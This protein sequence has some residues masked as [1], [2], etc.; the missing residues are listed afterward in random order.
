MPG[1]E[2]HVHT[3]T[4]PPSPAPGRHPGRFRPAAWL[5]LLLALPG[6]ALGAALE[7]EAGPLVLG[8]APSAVVTL[9]LDDARPDG[10]RLEADRPADA[11]MPEAPLRLAASAGAFGPAER[12]GPGAYR[13]TYTLPTTRFPQIVLVA[14]WPGGTPDPRVELLRLPLHGTTRLTVKAPAGRKVSVEVGGKSFGPVR[15]GRSGQAVVPIVVPPGVREARVTVVGG[16]RPVVRK[17]ALDIP[18]SRR[19][20]AVAVPAEVVADGR[21]PVRVEVLREGDPGE[22]EVAA[23][24]IRVVASEGEVSLARAGPGAFTFRYVPAPGPDREVRFD[25]TVDGEEGARSEARLAVRAA[26]TST[27]IAAASA[28]ST[29]PAGPP[30]GSAP[31]EPSPARDLVEGSDEPGQDSTPTSGVHLGFRLGWVDSLGEVAGSR[32]G[33]GAWV[34]LRFG[35]AAFGAELSLS[36]GTTGA[37]TGADG[38]LASGWAAQLYPLTVRL[39]YEPWS[40]GRMTLA[41]GLGWSVVLARFAGRAGARQDAIGT[42]VLVFAAARYRVGPGHVFG[43]ASLGAAP[44]STPGLRVETAGL[45]LDAGYR[46]ALP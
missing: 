21:T 42:G 20:L 44:V 30:R 24:R 22:P 18:P 17:V 12:I 6:P 2:P 10:G 9:R 7:V 39:A 11:A 3:S 19:L 41:G 25:V 31:G 40:R 46:F 23:A 37:V 1:T 13:A 16:A 43:E 4:T 35:S 32:F 38:A 14:A 45:A 15:A 26:A 33:L 5:P 28:T 34:P 29:A 27:V 36:R 8:R